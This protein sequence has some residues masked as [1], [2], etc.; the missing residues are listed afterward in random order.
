MS[1]VHQ[2]PEWPSLTW[3]TRDLA[4]LLAAVRH[5][6]GRHLGRMESLD[7][8]LRSEANLTALTDEIVRSSAIEGERLEAEEVRSSVARRLGLNVAGLPTPSRAVEGVVEMMVD[9]TRR[10]D[11]SLTS[12]RLFAWHAA[13]FPTGR[14]GMQWI[15]VGT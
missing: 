4:H 8:D 6:Q 15:T 2:L 5:K 1:C 12:E 10:Y 3:T 14:S 11:Q 9:A 13:L 7:F